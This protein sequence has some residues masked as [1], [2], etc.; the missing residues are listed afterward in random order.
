MH[1]LL[2]AV[3]SSSDNTAAARFTE[4]CN[5]KDRSMNGEKTSAIQYVDSPLRLG[6]TED[7]RLV[8]A[9][10]R[11]PGFD[12]ATI[13]R[14]LDSSGFAALD[15]DPTEVVQ[16]PSTLGPQF[17]VL[18]K[19]F[20]QLEPVAKTEVEKVRWICYANSSPIHRNIVPRCFSARLA[21][22]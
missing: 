7:F 3:K 10:L 8:A 22:Y 21:T 17:T 2:A 16:D 1:Q 20:V 12:E 18:T 19:L 5:F 15:L 9:A 11:V 14:V 4:K 6:S 13:K